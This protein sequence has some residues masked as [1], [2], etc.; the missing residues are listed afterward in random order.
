M[1]KQV[2][3][4]DE[5]LNSIT[6]QIPFKN[7]PNLFVNLKVVATVDTI[8]A[9]K[10]YT[11]SYIN[12]TSIWVYYPNTQVF[13]LIDYNNKT[14]NQYGFAIYAMQS[15]S[16]K[17]YKDL[18]YNE[19]IYL[20]KKLNDTSLVGENILPPLWTYCIVNLDENTYMNVV[21][22]DTAVV[23]QDSLYN[24]YNYVSP[25]FCRFLYESALNQ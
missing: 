21:S 18:K 12:R 2:I 13:L 3:A 17:I 8:N 14:L 1:D 16:S 6:T 23:I 22:I 20:S 7:N 4:S 5:E 25:I 10:P 24:T 15:Y 19:L 11:A 9:S